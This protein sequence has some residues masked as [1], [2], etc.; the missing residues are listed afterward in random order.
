[1]P[2]AALPLSYVV[3]PAHSDL[4]SLAEV[5]QDTVALNKLPAPEPFVFNGDPIQ[6]IEWKTFPLL[7]DQKAMPPAEKLYCSGSE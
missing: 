6:W 2:V 7:I 3:E 4:L 5:F 1:M